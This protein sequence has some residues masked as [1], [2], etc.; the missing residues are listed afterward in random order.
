ML[1]T[2]LILGGEVDSLLHPSVASVEAVGPCGIF[3]SGIP[4]LPKPRRDFAASLYGSDLV[5]CGGNGLLAAQKV[6]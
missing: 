1:D 5:V 3:E 6:G 2:V 4:D